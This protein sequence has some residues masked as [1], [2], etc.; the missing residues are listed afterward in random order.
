MG[1]KIVWWK[2]LLPAATTETDIKG[3]LL[4]TQS[5]YINATKRSRRDTINGNLTDVQK[6]EDFSQL[7]FFIL[8][9]N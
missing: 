1:S 4:S 3:D 8:K 9:F 5:S 6:L 2:R 7:F